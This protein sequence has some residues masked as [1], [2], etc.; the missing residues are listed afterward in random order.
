MRWTDEE[1]TE[2]AREEY[3]ELY[4]RLRELYMPVDDYGDPAPVRVALA[5]DA[6]EALADAINAHGA[7]VM[8]PGFP[9]YLAG[10]WAKLEGYLARIALVI[11]VSRSATTGD[12][13]RVETGDILRAVALVDYFKAHARRVYAAIYGQ[14]P[15]DRL[16][17][18]LAAFL[19][20]RGG[21][22]R[23]QPAE[24]HI[25]LE[26]ECKPPRANELSKLVRAIADKT[27]ALTVEDGH[28]AIERDG[29]RTT[30]RYVALTLK[31]V[32]NV[33]NGRGRYVEPERRG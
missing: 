24:L 15:V 9:E 11:A 6:K 12:P 1:I 13:E 20:R 7:E 29:K 5:P 8:T 22:W 16:A 21:S 19:Q 14:N 2:A 27:P 10:P 28:E 3:R 32:V 25:Q 18:D 31:N 4:D 33:V 26:S 17:E 30:R 23:G